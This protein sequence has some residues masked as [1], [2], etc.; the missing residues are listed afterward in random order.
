MKFTYLVL[1]IVK[2][3]TQGLAL[4]PAIVEPPDPNTTHK[5]QEGQDGPAEIRE[6]RYWGNMGARKPKGLRDCRRQSS[7]E[8]FGGDR[9]QARE[10]ER[11]EPRGD[12]GV[13]TR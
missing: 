12:R 5:H 1:F 3:N 9:E 2:Y 8:P 7:R 11:D 6:F 4:I 13:K 10:R